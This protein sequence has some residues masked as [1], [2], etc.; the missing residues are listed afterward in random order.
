VVPQ[1]AVLADTAGSYVFIVNSQGNA[2]RRAVR[3]ADTGDEGIVIGSGLTGTERVVTTAGGFLR[4]GEPV[5]I[6]GGG[7]SGESH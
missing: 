4:D 1:T 7:A 6:A 5:Q 3:V 2:E